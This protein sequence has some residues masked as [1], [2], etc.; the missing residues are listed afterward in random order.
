MTSRSSPKGTPFSFLKSLGLAQE[1][2]RIVVLGGAGRM[3]N[4]QAWLS[5]QLM[6]KLVA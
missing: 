1:H 4:Q 3:E 6:M 2:L 5:G